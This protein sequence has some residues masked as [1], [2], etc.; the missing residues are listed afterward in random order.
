MAAVVFGA[1]IV[2]LWQAAVSVFD[3]KPYFLPAPSTVFRAFV[4]NIDLVVD[5]A[6]VSGGNAS[7]AS[8][9]GRCSGS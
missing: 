4:D 7:V 8:S 6:K 1:V 3:L 9:S 2:G 5:A